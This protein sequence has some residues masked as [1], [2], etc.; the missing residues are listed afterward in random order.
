MVSRNWPSRSRGKITVARAADLVEED[1]RIGDAVGVDAV[2]A[3]PHRAEL[4]VADGDGRG[5]APLLVDL[6]ARR[7]EVDLG[8]EGRFEG[9]VPVH[10]V[11]EQR[12]IARVERVQAGAKDVGDLAFVDEGG[13]LRLAHGELAA[14]FYLQ[15]AHG[16][17]VGKNAVLRLIPLDDTDKL[18]G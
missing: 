11:G 3:Q 2:T 7:E 14:V 10:Q 5:R 6:Q 13:H 15:V 17:A 18:L 1:A 8:L 9:L 16:I 12:Q 4:L